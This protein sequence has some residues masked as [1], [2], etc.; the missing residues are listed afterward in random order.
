M[1]NMKEI[2]NWITPTWCRW[3]HLN[4]LYQHQNETRENFLHDSFFRYFLVVF[5]QTEV[6]NQLNVLVKMVNVLT[7]PLL[8]RCARTMNAT[9]SRSRNSSWT[10]AFSISQPVFSCCER[11][12]YVCILC[13]H[14][15]RQ[16]KC[17]DIVFLRTEEIIFIGALV[18]LKKWISNLYEICP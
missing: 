16:N 14:W 4:S 13:F 8:F 2:F 3:S 18:I 15:L 17:T 9:H 10:D 5:C 7:F 12:F 6:E 11:L 1:E